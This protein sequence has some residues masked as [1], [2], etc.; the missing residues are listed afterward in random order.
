MTKAIPKTINQ[1]LAPRAALR[2]GASATNGD[3]H[4]TVLSL[5]S[6]LTRTICTCRGSKP[7]ISAHVVSP[8]VVIFGE[9]ISRQLICN[10]PLASSASKRS[11][12]RY[13][14]GAFLGRVQRNSHRDAS[15]R[16]ALR[17]T[18]PVAGF[19][20]EGEGGPLGIAK[21]GSEARATSAGA[22]LGCALGRVFG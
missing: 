17:L 15:I 2:G 14:T 10:C 4:C 13:L 5:P 11:S 7:L 6:A 20:G 1:I 21:G 12:I 22:A 8:A 16:C 9:A 19:C 3:F 18:K